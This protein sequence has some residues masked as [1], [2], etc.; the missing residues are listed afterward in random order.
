MRVCGGEQP[1][2][3]LEVQPALACV[4]A[5]RFSHPTA[6]QALPSFLPS[7]LMGEANARK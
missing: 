1:S 2:C 7:V 5:P 3:T 4:K 6:A